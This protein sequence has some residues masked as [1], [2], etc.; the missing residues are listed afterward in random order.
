M[1]SSSWCW[2]KS[3]E[4][5]WYI[6]WKCFCN[7]TINV[8][9]LNLHSNCSVLIA[10][11]LFLSSLV[12][13]A[14]P[15][16]IS[17]LIFQISYH[18]WYIAIEIFLSHSVRYCYLLNLMQNVSVGHHQCMLQETLC[19]P[20]SQ[21]LIIAKERCDTCWSCLVMVLQ[22]FRRSRVAKLPSASAQCDNMLASQM[23]PSTVASCLP[24]LEQMMP[25]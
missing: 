3:L 17:F 6:P 10:F 15:Y 2:L 7:P 21:W 5:A 12:S 24:V 16:T 13:L 8:S 1:Q 22:F 23:E 25:V 19:T 20:L 9:C 14:L 18:H 11:S 4:C